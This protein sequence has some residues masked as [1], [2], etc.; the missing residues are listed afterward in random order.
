MTLVVTD[1][2]RRT[3]RRAWIDELLTLGDDRPDQPWRRWALPCDARE[4]VLIGDASGAAGRVRRARGGDG[5][6]QRHRRP[7][8]GVLRRALRDDDRRRLGRRRRG[9]RRRA[10]RQ[11]SSEALLSDGAAILAEFGMLAIIDLLSGNTAAVVGAEAVA[12]IEWPT[13]EMAAAADTTFGAMLAAD[14]QLDGAGALMRT[15]RRLLPDLVRDQYW[16]ATLSMAADTTSATG[17]GSAAEILL[18]LLTPALDLTVTDPGLLYRGAAAHF[19]GL[20]AAVL[21]RTDLAVELLHTGLAT[22][23]RH[24]SGWMAA[25]SRAA[26]SAMDPAVAAR[27]ATAR[28]RTWRSH[29]HRHPQAATDRL[30]VLADVGDRHGDRA[31]GRDR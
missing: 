6:R 17:D 30:D 12:D 18:E 22:H 11:T 23:E 10:K 7:P 29:R 21:G 28:R 31:A 2:L 15:T 5:G 24:G 27:P 13:P 9:R 3:E 8:R 26:L 1:P 4:R 16:L 14:G 20:A 19:A 25:R